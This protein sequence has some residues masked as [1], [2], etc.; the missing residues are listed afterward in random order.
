MVVETRDMGLALSER[1]ISL[2]SHAVETALDQ[3]EE[4][5]R[6]VRVRLIPLERSRGVR[7]RLR[8]WRVAGPNLVTTQ[9][10]RSLSSSLHAAART[11]A[12]A[13]R[14][15]KGRDISRRKKAAA[16]TPAHGWT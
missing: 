12:R 4:Q 10:A 6:R 1:T 15:A 3:F 11:L 7:V 5:V 9:E 14:R 2:I 16:R 8:V 13:L